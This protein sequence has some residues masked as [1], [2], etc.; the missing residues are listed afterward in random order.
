MDQV[1]RLQVPIVA[2]IGALA[3]AIVWMWQSSALQH[4]KTEYENDIAA[5]AAKVT[6]DKAAALKQAAAERD[7]L[8]QRATALN[9]AA[10]DESLKRFAMPLA[11]AVRDALVKKNLGQVDEYLTE[12]VQLKGLTRVVFAQPD[13]KIT[14]ASDKKFEGTPFAE[15]YPTELLSQNEVTITAG[16]NGEKLLAMPIM[17][18]SARLGTLVVSVTPAPYTLTQA[19]PEA[20]PA[21]APAEA[22]APEK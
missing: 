14:I 17:G 20:A 16:K 6:A 19:A 13:G 11:W 10:Q 15:A 7:A 5:T 12:L 8:I 3:V 9:A 22:P 4:A 2:A 21:T 18:L 1:K